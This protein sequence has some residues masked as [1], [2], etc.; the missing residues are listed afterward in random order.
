MTELSRLERVD[1]R[2]VW[3]NEAQ[4]FTPWLTNNLDRLGEVLGLDL[5]VRER[6]A[7]VGAGSTAGSSSH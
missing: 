1:L 6:E 7:Q 2:E 4:D 5:E 3:P